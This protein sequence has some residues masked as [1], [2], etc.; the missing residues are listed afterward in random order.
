MAH[1][2]K[3]IIYFSILICFFIFLLKITYNIKALKKSLFKD[4]YN[5]ITFPLHLKKH[6]HFALKT[7]G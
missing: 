3:Q 5:K 6:L 2:K 1:K 4:I 7:I